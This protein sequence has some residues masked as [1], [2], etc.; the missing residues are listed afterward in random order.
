MRV[1]AYLDPGSG[2]AILQMLLAGAAGV[3][4]SVKMFGKRI[5]RTLM[6]WKRH[7]DEPEHPEHPE[8]REPGVTNGATPQPET[9]KEPV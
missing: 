9:E 1:L 4:V 2:S 6:F 7:D 3:V 8:A 5:F